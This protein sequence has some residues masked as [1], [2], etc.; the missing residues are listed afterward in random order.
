MSKN[1]DEFQV[2]IDQIKDILRSELANLVQPISK[3][4]ENKTSEV[5]SVKEET[6]LTSSISLSELSTKF[7]ILKLKL[8]ILKRLLMAIMTLIN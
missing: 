1:G 3:L 4:I 7:L 5:S 6:E 8:I 2:S